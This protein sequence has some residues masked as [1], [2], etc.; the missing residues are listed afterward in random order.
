MSE[1][2]GIIIAYR[3]SG[4][5]RGTE[6][7][8][9]GEVSA[10]WR[11]AAPVWLHLHL[12]NPEAR[13][14][15]VEDSGLDSIAAESLYIEDPRPRCD[16]L[17][18]GLIAALRGVN[19]N[20]GA[21]PEE[22][23]SIRLWV[24]GRHAVSVRRQKLLAVN[25]IRDEIA[26]GNGPDSTA[27]FLAA[28]AA[29]MVRRMGPVLTELDDRTDALEDALLTAPGR[30]VRTRLAAIRREAIALRRYIAPQREAMARLLSLPVPWIGAADK[31]RLR[32]VADQITRYVEDLDTI[33]ERAAVMQDEVGTRLSEQIN[34]NMYLLSLT[35]AVFLPLGLITG[36][37][38]VNVGGV[39]GEGVS[40]AFFALCGV[41]VAVAAIE[42][43]LFRT[44][45]FL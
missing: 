22:M 11:G 13:A 9:W 32:E 6:I 34:R 20:P 10:A 23:V 12:D 8:G 24:D 45:R 38:G 4:G 2:N 27:E 33:R 21:D 44:M 29:R 25:D 3:L 14:W 7:E 16:L 18:E 15:L 5:G 39:P 31:S 36:L 42:V 41:L 26:R 28:L 40:W 35:A 37:L 30:E 17:G 43:W 1:K 19:L